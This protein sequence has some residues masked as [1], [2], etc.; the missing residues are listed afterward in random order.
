MGRKTK[1]IRSINLWKISSVISFS[2][3]FCLAAYFLY[4][5]WKKEQADKTAVYVKEI[6]RLMVL[7][8]DAPVLTPIDDIAKLQE[9]DPLFF[10]PAKTGDVLLGFRDRVILY[11]P[12]IKKILNIASVFRVPAPLPLSPLRISLRYNGWNDE[13]ANNLKTQLESISANYQIVEVI[14]SQAPYKGDVVYMV[15]P[16]REEDIMYLAQGLGDSPVL[17]KLEENEI[18]AVPIDVIVAFRNTP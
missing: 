10:K 5:N 1:K 15:S 17:K 6:N 12:K 2:I 18:I 3:L 13:R 7:P 11:D 8:K 9:R 14:S 4:N 16:Q